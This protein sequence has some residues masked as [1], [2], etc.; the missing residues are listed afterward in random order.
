M[1]L[2]FPLIHAVIDS[3]CVYRPYCLYQVDD[4]LD[5]CRDDRE[6]VDAVKAVAASHGSECEVVG[7]SLD[8]EGTKLCDLM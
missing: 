2:L 5:R 1:N 3:H 4:L 8:D 6:F 7:A